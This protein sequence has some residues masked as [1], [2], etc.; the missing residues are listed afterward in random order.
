M[1]KP[2][3][4]VLPDETAMLG[5]PIP[6]Y[7][8]FGVPLAFLQ[9]CGTWEGTAQRVDRS[10]Q[11]IDDHLV[12]VKIEIDGTQYVQTNTVRITI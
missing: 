11:L 2:I 9:N 5:I 1:I 7:N 3:S 6:S 12:R 8:E 10:G 4:E